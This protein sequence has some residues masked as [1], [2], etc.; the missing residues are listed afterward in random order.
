MVAGE[1]DLQ[2]II[3][4]KNVTLDQI[5]KSLC[6]RYAEVL[7]LREAIRK[8]TSTSVSR[9]PRRNGTKRIHVNGE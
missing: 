4:S 9:K 7:A 5:E 3:V 2:R 6:L 1:L 8:E